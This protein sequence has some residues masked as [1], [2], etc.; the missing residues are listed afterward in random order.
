MLLVVCTG[1]KETM[2]GVKWLL[3]R[4]LK[5]WKTIKLSEVV[6]VAYEKWKW[7]LLEDFDWE[8]FYG[9]DTCRWLP[10]GGDHL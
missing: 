9:L 10:F 1:N 5:Q 2:L 7:F 4:G 6:R 8:N 3:T